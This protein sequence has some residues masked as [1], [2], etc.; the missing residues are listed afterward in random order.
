MSTD[1]LYIQPTMKETK[2]IRKLIVEKTKGVIGSE[3]EA[4]S[5]DVKE[6]EEVTGDQD[7][8]NNVGGTEIVA[9]II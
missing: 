4:F 8:S 7:V 9:D 3:E 1:F 2:K 6:E 5:L